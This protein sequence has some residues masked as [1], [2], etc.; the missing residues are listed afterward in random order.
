MDH[1]DTFFWGIEIEIDQAQEYAAAMTEH[2]G[3]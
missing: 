3:S 1:L 2:H